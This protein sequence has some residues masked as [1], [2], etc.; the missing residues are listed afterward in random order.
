[1]TSAL[2]NLAQALNIHNIAASPRLEPRQ[3]APLSF[4]T[5][6]RL[7]R[8][9]AQPRQEEPSPQSRRS[10]TTVSDACQLDTKWLRI[11]MPYKLWF[12]DSG[13]ESS[14][15]SG[16]SSTALG[17]EEPERLYVCMHVFVWCKF[18]LIRSVCIICVRVPVSVSVSMTVYWRAS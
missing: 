16:E 8:R 10:F 4:H 13:K 3:E 12:K 1:M 5:R 9:D 18:L 17:I 7:A 15:D 2:T 6:S 14:K 11:A